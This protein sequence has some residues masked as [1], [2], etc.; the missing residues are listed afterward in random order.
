MNLY[1]R[2]V[3]PAEI[4]N[5]LLSRVK[6]PPITPERLLLIPNVHLVATLICKT[7]TVITLSKVKV[8][9]MLGKK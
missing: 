8:S 9:T 7:T 3:A 4:V 2:P 1:R 5:L 6:A